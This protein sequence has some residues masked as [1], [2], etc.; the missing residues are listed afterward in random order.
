MPP[1]TSY[2]GQR[3]FVLP[4]ELGRRRLL[5]KEDL[6]RSADK[7][8]GDVVGI[9]EV[10]AKDL[11]RAVAGGR[12]PGGHTFSSKWCVRVSVAHQETIHSYHTTQKWSK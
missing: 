2:A 6:V 4:Q 12:C 7:V 8:L 10:D 3:G 9:L 11:G 1:I 5:L